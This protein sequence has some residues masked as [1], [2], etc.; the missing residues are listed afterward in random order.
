MALYINSKNKKENHVEDNVFMIHEDQPKE[1]SLE[2]QMMQMFGN[3]ES[4]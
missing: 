2:D 4:K 3:G 1:L